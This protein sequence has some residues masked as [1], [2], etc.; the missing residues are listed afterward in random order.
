MVKVLRVEAG[1][2]RAYGVGVKP[3]RHGRPLSDGFREWFIERTKD[4]KDHDSILMDNLDA[5][6]DPVGAIF[7]VV[8]VVGFV[9]FVR[10]LPEM[11]GIAFYYV[12]LGVD[13]TVNATVFV[14]AVVTRAMLRRPWTV[15]ARRIDRGERDSQPDTRVIQVIGLRRACRMR[16]S[17]AN[18]LADGTDL[19]SPGLVSGRL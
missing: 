17:V 9:E 3:V 4:H 11:L 5:V 18:A 13:H 1:S 6:D 2:S 16:D 10:E 19:H 14:S 8:A 12:L 7:P 15:V